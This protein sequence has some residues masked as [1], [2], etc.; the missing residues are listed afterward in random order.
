MAADASLAN[1]LRLIRPSL[2]FAALYCKAHGSHSTGR[3]SRDTPPVCQSN[4]AAASLM[5]LGKTLAQ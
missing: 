1:G 2:T 4:L 5:P 3:V